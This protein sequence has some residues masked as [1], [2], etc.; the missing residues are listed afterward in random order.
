MLQTRCD[1]L[2]QELD[3][4][5]LIIRN[6]SDMVTECL[7]KLKAHIESNKIFDQDEAETEL[8]QFMKSQDKDAHA[9]TNFLID[10]YIV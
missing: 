9:Y 7:H 3:S 5:K 1:Q 8:L 10:K 4:K 2:E 6:L